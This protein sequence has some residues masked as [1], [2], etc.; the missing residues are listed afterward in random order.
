L[1][2]WSDIGSTPDIGAPTHLLQ[3]SYATLGAF[4]TL[5]HW[6]NAAL[7]TALTAAAALGFYV[8]TS[9]NEAKKQQ[10]YQRAL[11][12]VEKMK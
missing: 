12:E 11:S 10:V 5:A 3:G 2:A 7:I 4:S 8:Y 1:Q 9:V 6:R